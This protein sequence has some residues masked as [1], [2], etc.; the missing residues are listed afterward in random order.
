M[1]KTLLHFIIRALFCLLVVCSCPLS[2]S[3]K[4]VFRFPLFY[5]P[6]S[7]DPVQD[8][9]IST[10]HIVQ[11]VYDGLVAFDSNLRVVPGLA[12]SWTVSRD[13]K[14]YIFTLRKDVRFHDG[15]KVSA[16]DVVASLTRIFGPEGQTGSKKYMYKIEGAQAYRD[17][18]TDSVTGI[19]ELPSGQVGIVLTEPYAA[20]LSILAMPVTKIVPAERIG[21]KTGSLARKPIGTGPFRFVSWEEDTI[22]LEANRSYFAGP[23]E[24]DG[25]VFRFYPG[26]ERGQAYPDFLGGQLDGCPIPGT[27]DLAELREKGYQAL[28]RPRISLMFYGMNQN[29]AP[30]N[31]PLVRRALAHAFDRETYAKEVLGSKHLPAF[32]IIPPGMPGYSPRNALATYDPEKAATLLKESGHPGGAGIPELVIASV[33][34]SDAAKRELEM[35]RQ[36][37][38]ALGVRV[39]PLFVENWEIF[40]KG[41]EERAYPL[42]RYA[43]YAD[44]PDPEDFFPDLVGTGT[45]HNFTGYSNEAI[46]A[47]LEKA[48]T[49]TDPS[50]RT[51]L[52]REAERTVLEA[53]PLIPVLFLSTQVVFQKGVGNVELPATG[54]PYL[55]LRKMSLTGSP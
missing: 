28:V 54:T 7:L 3:A 1:K 47:L 30:L 14:K 40:K 18:K 32:Q 49:E 38:S 39:K 29:M 13:G 34:H 51:A 9:L 26:E 16:A 5:V 42:Y 43:L 10:Y 48:R 12:E 19:R 37:L 27:A 24:L 21:D 45:S 15:R 35:F 25:I 36:D 17:G 53:P 44:I 41:I 46:D 11:Q 31:D 33:S 2:A 8:E 23:P 20:F 55:P 4:G 22:T 50:K 6:T 52:Y